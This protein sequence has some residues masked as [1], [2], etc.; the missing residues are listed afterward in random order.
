MN[1]LKDYVTTHLQLDRFVISC[2][3]LND[4]SN[5]VCVLNKTENLN[6]SVFNMITR[7]NEL[8]TLPK[9]ILRECKCKF[10]GR[11]CNSN[12]KWNNNKCRCECNI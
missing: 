2:N 11:K 9:H 6:L 5:T 1:T 4:H 3:N 12:Q 7:I 8:K 10:D